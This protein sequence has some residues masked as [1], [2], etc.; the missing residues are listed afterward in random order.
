MF[1]RSHSSVSPAWCT[2]P[3]KVQHK[4]AVC[5]HSTQQTFYELTLD[6]VGRDVGGVDERREALDDQGGMGNGDPATVEVRKHHI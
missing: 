4:R 2:V 5:A 1:T 3:L 6:S